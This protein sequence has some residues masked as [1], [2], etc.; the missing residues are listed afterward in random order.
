MFFITMG[1][2]HAL[3]SNAM[4]HSVTK[5]GH[6][7]LSS[8]ALVTSQDFRCLVSGLDEQKE[9]SSMPLELDRCMIFL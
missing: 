9:N 1:V 6:G 4:K 7:M 2:I 5:V 8:L 3:W